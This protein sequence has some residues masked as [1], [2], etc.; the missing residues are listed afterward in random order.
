MRMTR[1]IPATIAILLLT[2]WTLS[3]DVRVPRIFGDNMI[4]Q[5]Q[6]K[7]AV[8]G[9]AEPGETVTV[10]ASWGAATTVK[11]DETATITA[12]TFAASVAGSVSIGGAASAAAT[13]A[14]NTLSGGVAAYIRD[15]NPVENG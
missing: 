6:T 12:V 4:L 13:G 3:A 8:W 10:S 14:S 15:S 1:S 9:W 7:N 11:A 5:Q 2:C